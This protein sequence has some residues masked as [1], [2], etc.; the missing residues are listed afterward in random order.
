MF[1]YAQLSDNN[2]VIGMS[3]L[4]GE[5]EHSN[6]VRIEDYSKTLIGKL[7][8]DGKFIDMI[9]YAELNQD[10][11]VIGIK[12]TPVNKPVPMN[13]NNTVQIESLDYELIGSKYVNGEFVTRDPQKEAIE[14]LTDLVKT[15]AS[16]VADLKNALQ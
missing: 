8:E 6:M 16:D 3:S 15:L 7:Y 5:V 14:S 10:S 1:N 11:E 4:N 13:W 2:I 9:H 12:S